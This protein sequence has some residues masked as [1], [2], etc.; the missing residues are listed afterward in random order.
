MAIKFSMNQARSKMNQ[1][2]KIIPA[3]IY[4]LFGGNLSAI[5]A[6]KRNWIFQAKQAI[7]KRELGYRHAA[8][9]LQC[10]NLHWPV[11]ETLHGKVETP[12]CFLDN[13]QL[14]SEFK[15]KILMA[16]VD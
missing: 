4:E 1:T 3:E 12:N 16:N 2:W 14:T 7:S 13:V 5:E 10:E 11:E 6:T 15:T 8:A 9:V